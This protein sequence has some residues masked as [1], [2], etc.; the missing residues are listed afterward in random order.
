MN[1]I[2][3]ANILLIILVVFIVGSAVWN[4]ALVNA[5]AKKTAENNGTVANFT[6]NPF[7]L[8]NKLSGK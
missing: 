2:K 3:T 4:M 8:A 6:G 1:S 7:T 5:V